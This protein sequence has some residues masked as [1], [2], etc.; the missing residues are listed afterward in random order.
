MGQ[1]RV[2]FATHNVLYVTLW[3]GFSGQ[4]PPMDDAPD[5]RLPAI[6]DAPAFGAVVPAIVADTHA[7]AGER[8]PVTTACHPGALRWSPAR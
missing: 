2:E 5:F 7:R 1:A 8:F 4:S 3:Q 6:P